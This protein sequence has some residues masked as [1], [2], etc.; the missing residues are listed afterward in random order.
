MLTLNK[1]IAWV[2]IIGFLVLSGCFFLAKP[3]RAATATTTCEKSSTFYL[4]LKNFSGQ[5]ANGLKFELYEQKTDANGLPIAGDKVGGGTIGSSGQASFSLKPYSDKIYALKVWDK[6]ADR[7][8]FWFYG[9]ARFVCNYDRYV[10]KYLPA[11]T[12]VMRD[13]QNK[14][15]RNYNFSIYAQR[16]DADGKPFYENS[17]LIATL[18]TDGGGQATLYVAPYNPYQNGLTGMY[19]LAAKDANNN[20]SAIYNVQIPVESDRTFQYTFSSLSGE[21]RD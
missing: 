1:K 16:Y 9:A 15:K 5:I 11:L 3:G 6:K 17:D 4:T 7:G 18:K 21:I 10:T 20:N 19:V 12:V 13:S 14:L 8:E 2:G